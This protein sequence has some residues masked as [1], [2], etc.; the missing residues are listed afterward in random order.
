MKKLP[1]PSPKSW[2]TALFAVGM[3]ENLGPQLGLTPDAVKDAAIAA[4]VVLAVVN[5]A[6]VGLGAGLLRG[7]MAL[8][9][10]ALGFLVVWGF[11]VGLGD[12]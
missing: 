4:I 1:S 2:I 12:W 11:G 10:G 3:A 7:L 5:V 9:L 6:G 8:K